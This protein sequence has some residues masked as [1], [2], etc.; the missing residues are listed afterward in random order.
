MKGMI[1]WMALVVLVLGA[2][3]SIARSGIEENRALR[4]DD[5]VVEVLLE[6]PGFAD[7]KGRRVEHLDDVFGGTA[8]ALFGEFL[9]SRTANVYVRLAHDGEVVYE[10]G[11]Q[12]GLYPWLLDQS[13]PIPE[14]SSV[15]LAMVGLLAA[16]G[17]RRYRFS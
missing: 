6:I 9:L 10:S 8:N 13:L 5:Q 14:P 3:V 7:G 12:M 17:C 4:S 15:V 1:R 2:N 16:A 11:R